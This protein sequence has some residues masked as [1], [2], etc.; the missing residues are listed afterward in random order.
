MSFPPD[1]VLGPLSI[2]IEGYQ[3]P[4]PDRFPVRPN[5]HTANWIIV[6]MVCNSPYTS[7]SRRDPCL[8]LFEI[9]DFADACAGLLNEEAHIAALKPMEPYVNISIR[10]TDPAE[11][12]RLKRDFFATVTV[13]PDNVSEFHEFR[14]PLDPSDI[15]KLIESV[16]TLLKR[17]PIREVPPG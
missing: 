16:G 5:R 12:A 7:F 15:T 14:F 9:K 8:L 4:H 17:L 1:I 2:S 13:T 3:F 11:K 10:R 6:R